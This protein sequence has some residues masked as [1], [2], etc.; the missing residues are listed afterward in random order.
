MSEKFPKDWKIKPLG[1]FIKNIGDGGTPSTSDQSNFGGGIPWI[2]ISDI[3]REIWKTKTTLSEKG[4]KKSS[5][6][7]WKPQ[8]VILST[9]ATIGQVGIAKTKLATKQGITG[10]ECD[11]NLLP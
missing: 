8:T 11:D 1:S 9:G 2:V 10:I 5:S 3:Q 4:L 6:K 7:L